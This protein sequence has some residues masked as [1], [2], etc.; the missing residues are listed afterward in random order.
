MTKEVIT[1]SPDALLEEAAVLMRDSRVGTLVVVKD[2]K[3]I[4]I[5]T[6]SDIFEAFIDLLGFRETG[7]RITIQAQDVPGI[8][9]DIAEIF[10]DLNFN[11]THIAVYRGNSGYS[12]IVIRTSSINTDAL[13]E[14]LNEHG[15]KIESIIRNED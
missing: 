13:E 8:L 14:K 9:A 7:S 5:I 10:K 3:L 2:D 4:G 12:D 1:I 6:E 11:I 15:Y